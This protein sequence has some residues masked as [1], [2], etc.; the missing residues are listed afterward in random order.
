[1]P[2]HIFL[3]IAIG[4][5]TTCIGQ[6]EFPKYENGLIYSKSTM[7][8]LHAIVDSLN[9]KYRNCD[10]YRKYYSTYQTV[11]HIIKLDTLA[12]KQAKKDIKANISFDEFVSKYPYAEVEKSVLVIKYLYQD[13]KDIEYVKYREV[14]PNSYSDFSVSK[15]ISDASYDQP[16]AGSWVFDYTSKSKYS[17]ESLEAFYFPGE[18]SSIQIPQ[19][20]AWQIGY[21]DCLVDTTVPKMKSDAENGSAYLPDDWQCLDPDQQEQLLDNLRST[22]VIGFCSQDSRPREHAF[23]IALV[24]AETARW[25]I[26][27]KAHLDIMNDRFE[28]M[29]DG[30]YAWEGRKTYIKELEAL[31]I[32]V[33][34]LLIGTTLRIEDPAPH[35]YFGSTGR[36]G[37]AISE[38][39]NR[40]QFEDLMLTMIADDQLD[41]YNR[42]IMY[43][44]FSNYAH[45]LKDE[46]DHEILA[47]KLTL[48]A[49]KL[50]AYM[51]GKIKEEE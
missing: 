41:D 51:A 28:R 45:Y 14:S 30:S 12:I 47:K 1:M 26:F 38:S 10:L 9:L 40:S 15:K 46:K 18:F 6:S 20:Y 19:K 13:Y 16:V 24:S 39:N 11:A 49:Q 23:N 33:P 48:A 3:L 32:N 22:T 17:D 44:L 31:D 21:A 35:H 5:Y 43:F 2:K 50:P 29:S 36:L 34:D 25:E 42:V 37:R 7:F 27:L 8:K 4:F